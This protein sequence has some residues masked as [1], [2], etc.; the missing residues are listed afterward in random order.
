MKCRQI[1]IIISKI[2]KSTNFNRKLKNKFKN[3][4]ILPKK[5]KKKTKNKILIDIKSKF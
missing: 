2:K 3:D 4:Y 5:K 1:L